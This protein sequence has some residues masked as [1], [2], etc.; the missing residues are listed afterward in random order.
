MIESP[1]Y[2]FTTLDGKYYYNATKCKGRFEF[3]NLA[4]HKNHSSLVIPKAIYNYFIKDQNPDEYINN[5]KDIFD[6]CIGTKIRGSDWVFKDNDGVPQQKVLRLLVSKKGNKYFKF[7]VIDK[8]IINVIA[9][10]NK[11]TLLNKIDINKP[12]DEYDIDKL[13]YLGKVEEEITKIIPTYKQQQLSL[14]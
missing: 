13:Y 9:G 14:F 7:N 4:L 5:N 3:F 1:H 2:K 10:E 6:F 11:Q 12:F 8:R